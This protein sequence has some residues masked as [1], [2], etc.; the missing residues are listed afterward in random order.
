MGQVAI[1]HSTLAMNAGSSQATNLVA[2]WPTTEYVAGN[3]L[4]DYAGGNYHGALNGS[5][6]ATVEQGSDIRRMLRFEG[7]SGAYFSVASAAALN[8]TGNLSISFWMR[9]RWPSNSTY[10]GILGK[11]TEYP[12]SGCQYMF[13]KV[14]AGSII[15]WQVGIGDE[16]FVV[17][18]A[19]PVVVDTLYHVVGVHD[20]TYMITY[21]NDADT[22]SWTGTA[23]D[24]H[25]SSAP[26]TIGFTN[27]AGGVEAHCDL[28]DI[29]IY[30]KA[31]SAT[32]IATIYNPAT[33]WD[34]YDWS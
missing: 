26:L 22:E 6:I 9:P 20:G 14:T 1:R 30:D 29:R 23:S 19:Q 28:A 4:T 33:R 34:L 24:L 25:T 13:Y 11:G 31:L 7:V 5:N 16:T 17:A 21:L 10:Y 3:A 32:E 15:D 12:R 8:I 18:E 27:T 2:W